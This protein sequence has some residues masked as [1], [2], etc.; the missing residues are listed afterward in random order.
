ML[1]GTTQVQIDEDEL[2]EELNALQE[3]EA[4]KL[5]FVIPS[6]PKANIEFVRSKVEKEEQLE[7]KMEAELA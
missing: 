4:V 5:D 1:S 7:P 6:A 2:L 3:E